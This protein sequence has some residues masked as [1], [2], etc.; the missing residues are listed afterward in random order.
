MMNTEVT[1]TQIKEKITSQVKV[2][3]PIHSG[4]IQ[5][6]LVS[7]ENMEIA[8][9]E[10]CYCFGSGFMLKVE[11]QYKYMLSGLN[12]EWIAYFNYAYPIKNLTYSLVD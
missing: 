9:E 3:R 2:L 10:A 1:L 12:D 5:V 8:V 11:G 6:V 7:G 4:R